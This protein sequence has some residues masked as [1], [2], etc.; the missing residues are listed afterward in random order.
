[1]ADVVT[2]NTKKKEGTLFIPVCA[3]FLKV[4]II[5]PLLPLLIFVVVSSLPF[6]NL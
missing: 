2:E 3:H 6:S 5:D 1:M 4:L